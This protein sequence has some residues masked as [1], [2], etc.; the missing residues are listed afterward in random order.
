MARKIDTCDFTHS[1]LKRRRRPVSALGA[2]GSKRARVKAL[3]SNSLKCPVARKKPLRLKNTPTRV[4]A[5]CGCVCVLVD[6]HHSVYCVSRSLSL[7][8]RDYISVYGADKSAPSTSLVFSHALPFRA[9]RFPSSSR[10][11]M[12]GFDVWHPRSLPDSLTLCF[13]YIFL[14][15]YSILI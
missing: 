8:P 7:R 4:D 1:V 3:G 2:K 13:R 11:I 12:P 15:L 6:T 9:S 5:P 14:E 10:V